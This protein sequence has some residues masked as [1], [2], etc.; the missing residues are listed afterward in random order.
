MASKVR[1]ANPSRCRIRFAASR[2][3]DAVGERCGVGSLTGMSVLSILTTPEGL[4]GTRRRCAAEQ[5]LATAFAGSLVSQPTNDS[6]ILLWRSAAPV[7]AALA[8]RGASSVDEC[9]HRIHARF[10]WSRG[11]MRCG[12][13]RQTKGGAPARL[14]PRG[15]TREGPGAAQLETRRAGGAG[16]RSGR[17]PRPPTDDALFLRGPRSS[18]PAG[19]GPTGRRAEQGTPSCGR[20]AARDPC[21]PSPLRVRLGPGKPGANPRRGGLAPA[22]AA[23]A[24][25]AQRTPGPSRCLPHVGLRSAFGRDPHPG[26]L[27]EPFDA[28]DRDVEQLGDVELGLD[29]AGLVGLDRRSE[30]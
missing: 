24:G 21:R 14:S 22:C 5:F 15:R 3:T 11:R 16:G 30:R 9:E 26:V 13:P 27:L 18:R 19:Q 1:C 20:G 29:H 8:R 17:R 25:C 7:S 2:I 4:H 23:G 10:A 6:A 12:A 28:V